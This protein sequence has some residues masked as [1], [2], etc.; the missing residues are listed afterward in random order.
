M[1]KP[2]NKGTQLVT[3]ADLESFDKKI[4]YE[5]EERLELATCPDLYCATWYHPKS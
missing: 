1:I 5:L 3:D 4:A 2:V